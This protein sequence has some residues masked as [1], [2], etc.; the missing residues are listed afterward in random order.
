MGHCGSN[1]LPTRASLRRRLRG[2]QAVVA[3]H[4]YGS[5]VGVGEGAVVVECA[6]GQ[7]GPG[8]SGRGEIGCGQKV[9]RSSGWASGRQHESAIG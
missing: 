1:A 6:V 4:G 3:L 8:L 5:A 9:E 2:A 7:H